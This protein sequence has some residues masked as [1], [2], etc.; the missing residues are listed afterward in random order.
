MRLFASALLGVVLSIPALAQQPTPKIWDGVFT[1]NQAMRGK[2]AFE[3]SC[4]RC[5]NVALVGSERGPAIKGPVFLSHWEMDN[6][7]GLFIKIRDTMPEGGPGTVSD[8]VKIDILSYVLQQNGFPS[9]AEELKLNL[10]SLEDIRMAK[11]GIWD[12]VFTTVQ[13]ER[14]KA[15][16]SQNG[17]NGCHGAELT[18]GRGPALKGDGFIAEWENGSINRLFLKIRESMPPLNAEQ[19]TPATK[20]DIVTYLLQVNGFPSGPTALN[21]DDIEGI[22]IVR[23]GVDAAGPPNFSLVAAIGC[24]TQSADKRWILTNATEPV[25]TKEETPTPSLLKASDSKPLGSRTFD[26][27]SVSPSF[28]PESHRSHKVEVRGLLYRGPSY[29]E[30]NL[31]SLDSVAATCGN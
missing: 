30:L 18:G 19:V 31:T 27:V 15:A 28:K 22:Q 2:A 8:E 5:H 6:L 21:M 24:L 13:A 3:G 17:C 16:L 4:A 7:A 25:A 11:K 26:L 29:V 9:G 12:G 23:R 14:G 10:S 1:A 20:L